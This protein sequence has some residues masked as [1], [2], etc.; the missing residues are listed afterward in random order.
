MQIVILGA[1]FT[2]TAVTELAL[3]RG[4]RVLATTRDAERAHQLEQRGAQVL[5]APALPASDLLRQVSSE[6]RVLVTFPPDGHTD[7]ALAE[8]LSVCARIV[9]I[10]ST[11]VYGAHTGLLDETTPVLP[12]TPRGERRFAAERVWHDAGATILRAPAIYGP[13]RG[14][15]LRLTRGDL[16]LGPNPTNTISRIHR[17]D[18]A[19][20]ALEMLG[21]KLEHSTYLIGDLEPAPHLEVVNWLATELRLPAPVPDA[22]V[23]PD[24][25]LTSD[26]QVNALRLWHELELRPRYPTYREGLRH[27]IRVDLPNWV[28][29]AS[30]DTVHSEGNG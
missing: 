20:A 16:K 29:A 8:A 6:S 3:A 26:R 1:G 23:T 12:N 30:S 2:G 18:L 5:L 25:T 7:A 24:E 15:H 10:S 17:D 13:G 21:R 11:A 19:L 4:L 28:G 9:Y 27:C 22:S 14:L